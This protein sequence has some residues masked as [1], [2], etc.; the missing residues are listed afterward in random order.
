MEYLLWLRNQVGEAAYNLFKLST[1]TRLDISDAIYASKQQFR[2]ELRLP[3]GR[4]IPFHM[5]CTNVI[6]IFMS[7]HIMPWHVIMFYIIEVV[8]VECGSQ[9]TQLCKRASLSKYEI[10]LQIV[11]IPQQDILNC[12][13]MNIYLIL[14]I[15]LLRALFIF[16]LHS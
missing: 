6:S 13:R 9:I 16:I 3:Y 7:K 15:I 12:T 8:Q 10:Q 1:R 11:T 5:N 2:Q 14:Y 4:L